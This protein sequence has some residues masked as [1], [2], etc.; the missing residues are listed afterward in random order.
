MCPVIDVGDGQFRVMIW[1]S[2][3]GLH[4]LRVLADGMDIYG[5]PFSVCVTE[6]K[7]QQLVSFA[8]GLQV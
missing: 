3:A 2:T 8:K 7:R 6:W 4:Q 5:S 1:S